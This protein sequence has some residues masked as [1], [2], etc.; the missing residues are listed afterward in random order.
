MS[1]DS[2]SSTRTRHARRC[3]NCPSFLRDEP[4]HA[5]VDSGVDEE[6]EYPGGPID[7]YVWAEETQTRICRQCDTENIHVRTLR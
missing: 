2:H 4:D 5:V 7:R 1:T 3:Q 6:Y